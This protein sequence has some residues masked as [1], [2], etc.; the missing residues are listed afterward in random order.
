[1]FSKILIANRGE[2][3]CRIIRSAKKLGIKT[4][5]ICSDIDSS[6]PHVILADEFINIGGNSSVESY[7]DI[8]KIIN[9]M[10]ISNVDAV[11][12]GYG[13]LSENVKFSKEVNKIGKV[14]IGPPSK[15]ISIMGD[16]IESKKVAYNSGVSVVPGG[17]NI[18]DSLEDAINE[19]KSIGYPII[20]KASAGGGG[21]G[22]RVAYNQKEL[23]ENFNSAISE[24]KSSFGDERVFIEKFIEKP[25]HIEIQVFGDKFGNL[26]HLGERECTIQRR[27]QK[28]I[29]EAPSI[30]VDQDL[31]HKMSKQAIELA[32]SVG[33][34]SAGTVEFVVD[35][36]KNFYFLEM[37]TRLQVEHPV[38][39]LITNVDLVEL[40]ISVAYGKK[41]H[42]KQSD[43]I[44][45]GWAIESRIYAEDS[46][47]NFLPSIGRLTRYIEPKSKKIRIDSGV[48]EGSEISMYYDPMI[49]KLCVYGKDRTS[50]IDLMINALDRYLI[51]G[52]NTNKE[53]LSNILQHK[54]FISGDISTKFI[55]ENYSNGFDPVNTRM[56]NY[57]EIFAVA[58]FIHF[59]YMNRAAS[60][61]NQVKGFNRMIDSE[62]NI[63][64]K[65]KKSKAKITFNNYNQNYDIFID[66]K[67]FNLKSDWKIGFPLLSALIE[68]KLLY[69]G[70]I[71]NGPKYTISHKSLKIEIIVL[72][73]R[74]TELNSLM[75]PR[76]K[77]DTSKFLL[78]PMPGLLVSIFVKKGQKVQEGESIAVIEAMKMENIIKAEKE[79]IIKDI[80]SQEGDSLLVD[81]SIM[82]FE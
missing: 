42:L 44:F 62:W 1:M 2:I 18:I 16:K 15:A 47:R 35:K 22:M 5:A 51:N 82:E 38:T 24:A 63:I 25:R 41:L 6:A 48:V 28:V 65:N 53:F 52:V 34:Y 8:K 73:D 77:I 7:L 40:M 3:A 49:S 31:R 12:P 46:T 36:N 72:S 50:A 4:V 11:H 60:I 66:K 75:I 9:A 19:S 45:S 13:F 71:R 68:N 37:N 55:E 78:S 58:L 80:F 54:D 21:K 10:K 17:L 67:Y 76:K 32:K 39:E 64:S 59:K 74:H 61:S 43:I 79:L 29:E 69:F 27:H 56:K 70:I 81:Q 23:E 14:F 33:Y 26:I 30:F 57:D 20:V